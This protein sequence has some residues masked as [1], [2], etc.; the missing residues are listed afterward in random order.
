[1]GVFVGACVGV[2][3]AVAVGVGVVVGAG[4][5][6]T[7]VRVGVAVGVGVSVGSAAWVVV[8][9]SSHARSN[10]DASRHDSP[11]YTANR[12]ALRRSERRST[13]PMTST[14]GIF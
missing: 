14:E 13:I 7:G 4:V 2:A 9:P 3:A 8:A 12:M 1:M 11:A 10:N 5:G 6:G